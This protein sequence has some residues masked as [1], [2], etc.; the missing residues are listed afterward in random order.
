[1][2]C[3]LGVLG[4]LVTFSLLPSFCLLCESLQYNLGA[5][6]HCF[7]FVCDQSGAF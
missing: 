7:T 4:V 1:M 3:V 6:E 2:I 5:Q